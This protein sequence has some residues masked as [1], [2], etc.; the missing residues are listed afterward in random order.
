MLMR[1]QKQGALT[2]SLLNVRDFAIDKHKSVDDRPYG[3]GPGMVMMAQPLV[4]AIRSVKRAGSRV[5]YLS[6]QGAL[7][8]TEICRRLSQVEDL[9]LVCGHYEGIDQ[10]VIESEVDEEISIGNYILTNGC[11]AALVLLDGVVRFI[12]G[13][14]G[15]DLSAEADSFQGGVF[16]PPQYTRPEEFEGM[17]VPEELLSGNHAKI[18]QWRH[19]ASLKKTIAVRGSVIDLKK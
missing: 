9:V 1:A 16:G 18:A 13:V 19:S 15:N 2:L 8:N 12:P 17:R 14:L 5:V 3:G 7:L 11:L 6:P 10:R 4:A